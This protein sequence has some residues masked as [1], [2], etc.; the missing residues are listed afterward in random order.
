MTSYFVSAR[1]PLTLAGG[2]PVAPGDTIRRLDPRDQSHVDAGRLT[3]IPS[4]DPKHTKRSATSN[5]ED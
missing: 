5:P 2:R 1:R 3:E 4:P